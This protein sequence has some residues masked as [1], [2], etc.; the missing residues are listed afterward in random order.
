MVTISSRKQI[1]VFSPAAWAAL[2]A[3]LAASVGHAQPR[4]DRA[5]PQ[6][7][8]TLST[9]YYGVIIC[10][11]CHEAPKRSEPEPVL[12]R[13]TEVKIWKEQDKHKDAYV[14]LRS[15]RAQRMSLILG[16]KDATADRSCLSCHGV[17]I[18][19][20]NVKIDKTFK[21][22]EGVSC[23][24]CHGAHAEWVDIHGARLQREKWRALSRAEK[25][26]DYGMTDLWNP[27]TRAKTCAACHIG[28][29][30]QGKVITHAM[31]AAGHPPLPGFEVA[32]FS[33]AMPRH[34]QDLKEKS[35][36]VQRLLSYTPG[37]HEETKAVIIGG[38]VELREALELLAAQAARRGLTKEPENRLLDLAQVDCYAC[39]HE[40][41]TPSWRQERGYW[42]SPG[43]PPLRQW[44]LALVKL[45]IDHA[46]LNRYLPDFESKL[47]AL[48]DAFNR[49]PFGKLPEVARTARELAECC[50]DLESGLSKKSTP[51]DQTAA[52][53]LLRYLC[54]LSAAETPD[55]DSARQMAWA[56]EVIYSE[57][58]PKPAH[59]TE[60]QAKLKALDDELKLSLPSGQQHQILAELPPALR[61]ISEYDPARFQQTF[62]ELAR[63]LPAR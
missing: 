46:G 42:G 21:P 32:T 18:R 39:H 11:D 13:C 14:V 12:C 15:E 61:K 35:P 63:I 53:R 62:R 50:Q 9:V 31:Y 48:H 6:P 57:L 33:N 29:S 41:K 3:L 25:E 56:F 16:I 26:R 19:D 17:D 59:D 10:A 7:K 52:V 8:G 43:R 54:V 51:Y 27:A 30:R 22:E 47:R 5:G 44:P 45:G 58:D 24:A 20:P 34:W 2:S 55:Y 40:L 37:V 49:Q 28:D 4:P 60:I 38:V 23:V 1:G 36:A